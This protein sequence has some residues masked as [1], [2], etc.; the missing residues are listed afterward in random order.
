MPTT[1]KRERA[2]WRDEPVERL[3]SLIEQAPDGIFVADLDGRYT[4]VNRAGCSMLGYSREELVGKTIVDL[5]PPEDV[6]RLWHSKAQMAD[7]STHVAEWRLRRKDGSYLPV[8]VSAKILPDGRWQGFVRDISERRQ[9]EDALRAAEAKLT[10]LISIAAEGVIIIDEDQRIVVYN[11][12]AQAIFGW[13]P[14]EV[15]GQ[16]I[17]ELLPPARREAHRAH[18]HRFAAETCKARQMGDQER[19]IVG[20]RK[21]GEEFPA[22]ATIAKLEGPDGWTFAVVLR[23]VSERKRAEGALRQAIRGRDEVLGIVAHDLRNPLSRISMS[24][25]LLRSCPVAEFGPRPVEII[26]SEAERMNRLIDDMLDVAKLD[27]G[28]LEVCPVPVAAGA[29]LREVVEVARALA[30][31]ASLELR[32]EIEEHLPEVFVDLDR[33]WQVFDN[34]IGNAIKFTAPGGRITIAGSALDATILIRIADTGRGIPAEDLPHVFDRFWQA[35]RSDHRSAGLGLSIV[36]G[37]VEA[38]GGRVWVESELGRGTCFSFTL[39]SAAPISR[40]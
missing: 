34:L 40:G 30:A 24:A 10:D 33:I 5:I 32:A 17:H 8:E 2:A 22:E 1:S 13:R 9:A 11:E 20:R 31:K 23:D 36:A 25:E 14:K 12:G 19:A 29:L 27:A 7:G 35:T 38:H 26:A 16:S 18:I 15:I 4:E 21:T 3:A 28:T 39:P 6:G 37:I